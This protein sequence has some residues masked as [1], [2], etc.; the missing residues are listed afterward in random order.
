[1][2]I[3][4]RAALASSFATILAVASCKDSGKPPCEGDPSCLVGGGRSGS[5]NLGP[6]MAGVAGTHTT[7]IGGTSGWISAGAGGIAGVPTT[8]ATSGVAGESARHP[9]NGPCLG[10]TPICYLPTQRCVACLEDGD[11]PTGLV[12]DVDEHQC[13]GCTLDRH[14]SASTPACDQTSNQCVG[15]TSNQ[16]CTGVTPACDSTTR[17]CVACITDEQCPSALPA[18]LAKSHTCVRCTSDLHCSGDTPACDPLTNSCVACTAN[19]YCAAATPVCNAQHRCVECSNNEHCKDPTRKVCQ[20]DSQSCVECLT[21]ADCANAAGRPV[22]DLSQNACVECLRGS[23]CKD[24]ARPQCHPQG[25]SCVACLSNADCHSE[26]SSRCAASTNT[27][28]A[29]ESNDDCQHVDGKGIC[30]AVEGGQS[31][32]CVRCTSGDESACTDGGTSYSCD[33]RSFECTKTPRGSRK[34]CHSCV[35]D[36]ECGTNEGKPDPNSRCVPMSFQGAPHG[37]GGYCLQTAA[38]FGA[39]GCSAPFVVPLS[40]ASLSGAASQ[41]YCGINQQ[42]TTCEALLDLFGSKTCE[43]DADCGAGQGGLCKTVGTNP[44]RCTIACAETT[45]CTATRTCSGPSNGYCM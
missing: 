42:A 34:T 3:R 23:D 37:D 32:R 30:Q 31:H 24:A 39:S 8:S 29:C 10:T 15:C 2:S 35:A 27:C 6:A 9:C 40:A 26:A 28:V 36:S 12:C 38:S 17:S 7:T 13:V 18:C 11:C 21:N 22:C 1:M 20:I 33:P 19:E 16:Y 14:C 4:S 41:T 45:E 43:K 44:N 5:S 25:K